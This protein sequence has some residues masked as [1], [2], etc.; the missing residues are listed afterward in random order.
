MDLK[1]KLDG[2]KDLQTMLFRRA[3]LI[4]K[5]S[6]DNKM[7]TFP[8]YGNWKSVDL[9]VLHICTQYIKHPLYRNKIW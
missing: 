9:G 4:S 8:F 7:S 5:D 3:W 1:K 2:R 6:L